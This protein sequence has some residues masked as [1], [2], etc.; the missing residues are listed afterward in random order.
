[1]CIFESFSSHLVSKHPIPQTS[2]INPCFNLISLIQF[3]EKS[4][5]N[6]RQSEVD[7]S[8]CLEL[9]NFDDFNA[10]NYLL[11]RI[12]PLDTYRSTPKSLVNQ[13]NDINRLTKKFRTLKY[14]Q[15]LNVGF[16][17]NIGNYAL[18]LNIR[19]FDFIKN[20]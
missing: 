20:L 18:D 2:K 7:L 19:L 1:M 13:I 4:V 8:C 9:W 17:Y 3:N 6:V 12:D 11:I 14:F 5:W 16:L 10:L 15:H